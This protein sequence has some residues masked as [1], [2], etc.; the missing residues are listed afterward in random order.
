MN[1]VNVKLRLQPRMNK[2][3]A[4]AAEPNETASKLAVPIWKIV[5]GVKKQA[6]TKGGIAKTLRAKNRS[7]KVLTN[8]AKRHK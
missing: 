2:L 7:A 5:I 3:V 1:G 8:D 4:S 6:M